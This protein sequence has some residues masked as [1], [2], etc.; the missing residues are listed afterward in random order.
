MKRTWAVLGV[1]GSSAVMVMAGALVACNGLLGVG[2]ASLES[3]D[4]GSGGETSVA[5]LSCANY[6]NVV[7]QNCTGSD[8]EYLS[9][10]ICNSMCPAFEQGVVVADTA[11]DTL[12]CRLF[13]ANQAAQAP[14]T[15]CR[16]AGPLGGGHCGKTPCAPFC[17]QDLGYC[18]GMNVAYSGAGACLTACQAYPYLTADAG[19]T[20]TESG[21]T[22]NCRLWHLETAYT[23]QSFA[24]FHCAHTEQVSTMC[25]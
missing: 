17:D 19:D 6:C 4:G 22:L 7:M 3:D 18:T 14:D 15:A 5:E 1:F 13:F 10:A 21:N 11:D 2:T 24:N 12:G 8:A 23:S 25:F 20:T 9:S 16:I